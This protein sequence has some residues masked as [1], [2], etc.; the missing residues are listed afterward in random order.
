MTSKTEVS[1]TISRQN[2]TLLF[3]LSVLWGC[4]FIFIGVAVKELPALL[5]VWARVGLA[6]IFLVPVHLIVI[7][8]LPTERRVWVAVSGMALLNNIIPFSLIVYG[9]H[10]I[11]AGLASVINATTPL[12]GAAVMALAGAEK[13]SGQR[14]AGLLIGLTGVAVLKGVGPIDLNQ[15]TIGML[16][17]LGASA[18]YGVSSLWAKRRL[19]GISPMTTATCQLICSTVVMTLLASLFSKPDRLF[20]ASPGIW[21]ALAGLAIFSTSIAYLIFFRIIASAGATSVLLVTMLIPISAILMGIIFLDEHL[22]GREI[23]GASIIGIGLLVID[24]RLV[25]KVRQ[26]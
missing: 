17:V 10:F 24:G 23:L 4:S 3:I 15:Q 11:S 9:Q 13:L 5:I 25:D 19:V 7:G 26:L 20:S 21:L 12:F 6:A 16:C 2:W 22:L 14:I 18:S 8:K 1:T